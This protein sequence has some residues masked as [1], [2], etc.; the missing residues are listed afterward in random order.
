LPQSYRHIDGFCSHTYSFIN[1]ANQRHW[2]K[3]HFKT[4]Q[5]IKNRTN[6]ETGQKVGNRI[7]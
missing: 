3:F 4:L 2:V 7:L 5:G 6:A 1:A